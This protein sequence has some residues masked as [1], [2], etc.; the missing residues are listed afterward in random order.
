MTVLADYWKG[1]LVL[2]DANLRIEMNDKLVESAYSDLVKRC[3][4]LLISL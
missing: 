4:H 2:A 3:N 1:E